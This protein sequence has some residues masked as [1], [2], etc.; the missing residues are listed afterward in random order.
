[1]LRLVAFLAPIAAF[2]A[3]AGAREAGFA[4]APFPSETVSLAASVSLAVVLVFR[5]TVI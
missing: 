3:F 1:M 4:A 5:G 2:F